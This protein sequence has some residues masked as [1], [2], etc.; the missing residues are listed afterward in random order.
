MS[1]KKILVLSSFGG[2]G[3]IASANTLQTLLGD[4]YEFETIYPIKELRICGLPA[5]EEFYNWMIANNFNRMTNFFAKFCNSLFTSREKKLQEQIAAHVEAY[6]PDI[7]ISLIPFVNFYTSEVARKYDLPFLMVTT[8]NDL[9]NWVKN[10]EKRVHTNFKVTI[11]TALP[12]TK[13]LLLKS[14]VPESSIETIGL[15]LRPQFTEAKNKG[16]LRRAYFV[17]TNKPVALI[18][19]GGTGS[20]ITYKYVKTLLHSNLNIHL[21]ICTGRSVKLADKLKRISPKNGNTID[22]IPFTEKVHELFAIADLLITKPGPGTINEAFAQ[23]LPILIDGTNPPLFW[24]AANID[25]VVRSK[26]G[27]IIPSYRNAA[28]AARKLL[29]DEQ[30]REEVERGYENIPKNRF[31]QEIKGL[32]EAMLCDIPVGEAV[33][34]SRNITPTL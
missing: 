26:V 3:H 16:E 15:P 7:I 20:R 11:G 13:G 8:D 4:E 5:G 2:Y 18:M 34:T 1:L 14:R 12:T 23:K 17:P 27:S 10:L 32:I 9:T 6:Q 30:T 22:I 24:E 21:M 29:L 33:M 19:M 31:A 25:L 28:E